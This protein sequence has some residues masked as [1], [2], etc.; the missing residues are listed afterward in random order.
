MSLA[1]TQSRGQRETA[2]DGRVNRD[3][4]DTH[5][6]RAAEKIFKNRVSLE[7]RPLLIPPLAETVKINLIAVTLRPIVLTIFAEMEKLDESLRVGLASCRVQTSFKLLFPESGRRIYTSR[8]M[9]LNPARIL[10]E[11]AGGK[12]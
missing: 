2:R 6:I 12:A 8:G 3:A 5:C 9:N 7:T 4:S 10:G 1:R 11:S